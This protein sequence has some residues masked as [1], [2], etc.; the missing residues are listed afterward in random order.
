MSHSTWG[1]DERVWPTIP[2]PLIPTPEDIQ[3]LR[4]MCP[5]ELLLPASSPRI[6]MLG[7]TPALAEAG[8]PA[9]AELHAVDYDQVMLDLFEQSA[10]RAH[11]HSARWQAMPFPDGHFDLVIGDCSLNALPGLADYDEVLK[12]IVRVSKSNAP[13]V[14]RFFMQSEPRLSLVTLVE[15]SRTEFAH[16]S[17]PSKRLLIALAASHEDGHINL[18]DIAERVREQWGEIGDYLAA[19]GQTSEE[20]A[21]TIH[22]YQ[23]NQYLNYPTKA[24]IAS[25]LGRYFG[26]IA[27]EFPTY[28]CGGYCPMV[29]CS[30]AA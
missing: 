3:L 7:A 12:E 14:S 21:R 9:A 29:R 24:R 19:L 13:L 17:N 22:I 28:D 23:R 1:T 26:Q 15:R 25:K 10:F 5:P 4:K 2:P 18:A 11:R 30:Q 6:L 8:W 16:Y 27:F 20:I